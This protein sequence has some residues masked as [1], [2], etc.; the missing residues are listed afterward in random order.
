[1]VIEISEALRGEIIPSVGHPAGCARF[2]EPCKGL[3]G[4][5]AAEAIK[6]ASY[7]GQMREAFTFGFHLRGCAFLTVASTG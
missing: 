1:M 2:S 4:A 5:R 3:P 6:P 7:A